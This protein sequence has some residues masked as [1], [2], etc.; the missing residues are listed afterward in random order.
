[1]LEGVMARGDRRLE[2]VIHKA[3]LKG[4]KFDGWSEY[5]KF[6][7]WMEAFVDCHIEPDFYTVR[8]RPHDEIFP[9]DFIDS[10]VSKA[11]LYK[12]NEMATIAAST[13]DCR[14]AGCMDCGICPEF[15]VYLDQKEEA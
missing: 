3:W 12:E 4:C 11:Y 13:P 10:G 15:G 8:E 7:Q 9:G 14:E 2:Q 6:G 1:M 5:F